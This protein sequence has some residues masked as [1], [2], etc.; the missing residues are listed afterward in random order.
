[1]I[2]SKRKD[3]FNDIIFV[4]FMKVWG[5]GSSFIAVNKEGS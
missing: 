3:F 5:L 2:L 4:E 1:M